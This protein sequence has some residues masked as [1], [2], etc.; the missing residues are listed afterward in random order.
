GNAE[1][2]RVA[3][4][5]ASPE[6][7]RVEDDVGSGDVLQELAV[8]RAGNEAY[9]RRERTERE[10]EAPAQ[11]LGDARPRE[12]QQ[13]ELGLRVAL[14]DGPD[15]RVEIRMDLEEVLRTVVEVLA[16]GQA[17]LLARHA[18][19]VEHG[20]AIARHEITG[21]AHEFLGVVLLASGGLDRVGRHVVVDRV[22]AAGHGM[23]PGD[24]L[25]RSEPPKREEIGERVHADIGEER[26]VQG[27]GVDRVA[28]AAE[29]ERE[30]H[31]VVGALAYSF[32]QVV[33]LRG[34]GEHVDVE[35]VARQIA[36]QAERRPADRV[37]ME[38][39]RYEADAQPPARGKR[40]MRAFGSCRIHRPADPRDLAQQLGVVAGVVGEIEGGRPDLEFGV[41]HLRRF[42]AEQFVQVAVEPW[43]YPID[44]F[45]RL[46]DDGKH[47]R[48]AQ[49]RSGSG[50]QR[51]VSV[52]E[53]PRLLDVR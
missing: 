2:Q 21:Q 29:I 22:D 28:D 20:P 50:L 48:A 39:G 42:Q 30:R 12:L 24:H 43:P 10:F 53:A 49:P 4:R 31:V 52:H 32:G 8:L 27:G 16:G 33:R 51:R 6:M 36:D 40:S 13:H 41:R 23:S 14:E 37:R 5:I 38:I 46:E 45:A 47:Q 35:T 17:E 1:G 19:P 25:N 9:S 26:Y 15:R 44:L 3:A 34:D 7:K 11:L 18:G